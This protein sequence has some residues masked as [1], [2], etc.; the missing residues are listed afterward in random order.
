MEI[1]QLEKTVIEETQYEKK[2]EEFLLIAAFSFLLQM[3]EQVIKR[4]WL[5]SALTDV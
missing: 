5:K 1:D 3:A 2:N 4:T